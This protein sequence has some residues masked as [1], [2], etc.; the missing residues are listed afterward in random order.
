MYLT[1]LQLSYTGLI[2]GL[3]ICIM[4]SLSVGTIHIPF[5]KIIYLLQHSDS[6]IENILL[7]DMR[8]PRTLCAILVGSALALTGVVLFYITRNDLGCPSLLGINQGVFLG[9]IISVIVSQGIVMKALF[10]SGIIGG[11]IA[12]LLTFFITYRI[13]FSPLKLILIGQAIN[14]FCYAACQCL[15]IVAPEQA[16]LLLI[17][18]NGSLA[19]S[20][21]LLLKTFGGVLI[22]AMCVTLFFIKKN[23]LLSLGVDVAKTLGL[24]V[25]AYLL[26]F[27]SM[28]LIIS[29]CSVAIV[30][31]LLF[32]PLL[33]VQCSKLLTSN[34]H[35]YH[36]ALISALL[37]SVL[38]LA[39][40]L[41]IRS[42]YSQWEA[43]LNVFI[44]MI[45]VPLLIMRARSM[46]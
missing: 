43:P 14:L 34:N 24:N 32:F 1:K 36:F 25:N 2:I 6:S 22:F 17:N 39:S 7:Y 40:D 15:L 37:G 11:A 23:Y 41:L 27:F 28:I 35:P 18:L 5:K 9:I 3:M 20:S 8:I 13:G 31:P 33:V 4:L 30:G 46:R 10:A 21:W 12:G 42:Q 19:N 44:A 26:L 29:T 38:L 45:G 16:D